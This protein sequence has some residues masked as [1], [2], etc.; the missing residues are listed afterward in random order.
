MIPATLD[1]V[2]LNV[3]NLTCDTFGGPERV[4]LADLL[5]CRPW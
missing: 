3:S 5:V 4:R 2:L 1:A